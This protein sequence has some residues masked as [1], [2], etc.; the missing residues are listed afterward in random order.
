MSKIGGADA[1]A[2]QSAGIDDCSGNSFGMIELCAWIEGAAG[3]TELSSQL[4]KLG[5]G[6]EDSLPKCRCMVCP[7]PL[8]FKAATQHCV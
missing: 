7:E 1:A 5:Q 4:S 2:K 3:T 6:Q 8:R